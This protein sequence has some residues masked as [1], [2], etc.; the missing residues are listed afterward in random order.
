MPTSAQ[1][2]PGVD[3]ANWVA[4][5]ASLSNPGI[6]PLTSGVT[7]RAR[8][9]RLSAA[10]PITVIDRLRAISSTVDPFSHVNTSRA[11]GFT[12]SYTKRKRCSPRSLTDGP[13]RPARFA[14]TSTRRTVGGPP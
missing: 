1:V 12:G 5:W 8:R 4:R 11:S 10:L 3:L 14:G 6:I 13:P 2:T 9:A 7:P